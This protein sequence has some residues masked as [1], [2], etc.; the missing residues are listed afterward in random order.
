MMATP[1][2]VPLCMA[3]CM[4]V[5]CQSACV[6]VPV[7]APPAKFTVG[8]GIAAG[9]M[10]DQNRGEPESPTGAFSF[11]AGIHPLQYVD[12]A[13]GV[14][15]GVGFVFEAIP[16]AEVSADPLL[17]GYLELGYPIWVSGPIRP[18]P[19]NPEPGSQ[20]RLYLIGRG[21]L[22][23]NAGAGGERGFGAGLG[24]GL[25]LVKWQ[26]TPVASISSTVDETGDPDFS[27]FIGY[28]FGEGGIGL[29]A[30]A[31]TRQVGPQQYN[32]LMFRLIFRTPTTLGL[33][34]IPITEF[35][36]D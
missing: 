3:V 10:T 4:A 1:L 27:A 23:Q 9:D 5:V 28:A 22:L 31:N 29:E 24:L 26:S 13:N 19:S 18:T 11:S 6:P 14:D 35:G 15:A 7:I 25:E 20:G 33:L 32:V 8:G 16:N 36:E 17:G 2:R 30:T 21:E 34:L 12:T